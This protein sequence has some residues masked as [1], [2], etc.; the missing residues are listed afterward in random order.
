MII[1]VVVVCLFSTSTNAIRKIPLFMQKLCKYK[2]HLYFYLHF[3]PPPMYDCDCVR[4]YVCVCGCWHDCVHVFVL[5]YIMPSFLPSFFQHCV[6]LPFIALRLTVTHLVHTHTQAVRLA[7][8]AGHFSIYVWILLMHWAN[9]CVC[10]CVIFWI[11]YLHL[12]L[13]LFK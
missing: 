13:Y 5:M 8:I 10:V 4:V 9:V 7:L 2:L 6:G 12:E 11:M 1:V 3:S